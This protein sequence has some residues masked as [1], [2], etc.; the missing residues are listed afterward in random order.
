[1][2]KKVTQWVERNSEG[3]QSLDPTFFTEKNLKKI[4]GSDGKLPF[5][6]EKVTKIK[7]YRDRYVNI[8]RPS[9]S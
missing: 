9:G 5:L 1:M 8:H 6:H 4:K 2:Y 3:E 7:E